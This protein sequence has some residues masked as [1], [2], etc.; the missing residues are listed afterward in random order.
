LAE[1]GVI[2]YDSDCNVSWSF[3][4]VLKEENVKMKKFKQ[5]YDGKSFKSTSS[6]IDAK[7]CPNDIIIPKEKEN[8]PIID[9]PLP[10]L[11]IIRDKKQLYEHYNFKIANYKKISSL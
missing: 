10:F 1:D 5:I 3:T 4:V 11:G 6:S 8:M 7:S 9:F 2:V